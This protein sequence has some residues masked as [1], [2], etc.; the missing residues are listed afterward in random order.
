MTSFLRIKATP[1]PSDFVD[2]AGRIRTY[3]P[4]S[5][6]PASLATEIPLFPE[7]YAPDSPLAHRMRPTTLDAFLGQRHLLAPGMPLREAI[8]R[9]AVGSL[10]F[11]GPPGCGKTTLAQLIAHNTNKHFETFSAVT[12]GIPKVRELIR[13]AKNRR[14][15]ENRGTTLFC[16]EIHRF[17]KAQQ[18]AFLPHVEEG[19]ITLLGATTENPSFEL[20]NALL[21]RLRVFVLESVPVTDLATIIRRAIEHLAE[22][23][24]TNVEFDGDAIDL[25]AKYA[26]GDA[27][28]A[29]NAT[30]AVWH[31]FS[32]A[33]A[34]TAPVTR[35]AVAAALE[36]RVTRFDKSGEEHFNQ[37][38]ALH[39]A[40]RG[41]SVEGALYWLA[42]MLD[43]GEDPMYLLRRL[44]RMASEDVGLTDP[45]ALSIT[46]AAKDT[47]HFLGAPEGELAIAEAVIYLATAPKSNGV[48]QAW[49][50]AREAASSYPAESVPMHIRNAPTRLMRDVGYGQGYRYDHDE[51]GFAAGQEYLPAPLSGAKWY[52]PSQYGFEKTLS[53]R[54]AW[55]ESKKKAA[56]DE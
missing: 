28:R 54:L 44:V 17:N 36:R 31:H 30:E 13:D 42:R 2:Q 51:D 24:N 46:L 40:I 22:R 3:S 38:S 18:D 21:S 1:N 5:F 9:D 29:L 56:S 19:I 27:R 53:E 37:I 47:F 8:E 55:W 50:S 10:V 48:Y 12:E 34:P 20:N 25:I 7:A 52:Q 6:E 33:D 26:D 39:K 43:G 23:G 35:E 16:D 4:F 15:T 49:R 32:A 41:S 45:R 11:W 14:R